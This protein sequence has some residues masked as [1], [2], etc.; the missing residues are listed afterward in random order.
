MPS[1]IEP[2]L[3]ALLIKGAVRGEFVEM[4]RRPVSSPLLG[5]RPTSPD[6]V[7]ARRSA[8]N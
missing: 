7:A 3:M 8:R 6:A 2:E 5:E 4:P 1:I